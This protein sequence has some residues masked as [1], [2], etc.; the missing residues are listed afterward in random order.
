MSTIAA[1]ALGALLLVPVSG[2]DFTATTDSATNSFA[3]DTLDPPT[4]LAAADGVTVDLG[5]SATTDGYA[6]GH[7]ILRSTVSGGPYTQIADL[8]P[9]SN[10]SFVDSAAEGT[11]YYVVRAYAGTWESLYS[12][13]VSARIWRAFDCPSDPDL[14]ACIRFDTDVSGTYLDESGNGNTVTHSNSS[15]VPGISDKAAFSAPTTVYG[16]ADSASLDLTD[17]MTIE[18]WLKLDSLPST[19]RVGILDNDGQYSLF[20]YAGTGLRC[21]NGISSLP[22]VP[23]PSGVWFHV[24]CAWD[25]STLTLYIDGSPVASMASTGT[26]ATINTD[27]VSLLNSSPAFN[28]PADGAMDNL[29]IWH[30]GRTQAQICA[31][32]GI[33]GC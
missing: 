16:M 20:V 15:Q 17:A 21:S 24:G 3:G 29:R 31:D 32:A 26:I 14:R 30:S 23:V 5:W 19:G 2:A 7:R 22:H 28:E 18:T 6:D 33:T 27:D 8:T 9:A 13:E 12:S 4:S 10:D 1:M 25:G 11:Y